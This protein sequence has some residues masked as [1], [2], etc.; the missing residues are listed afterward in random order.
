MGN[1]CYY[2]VL[3]QAC[4]TS[5]MDAYH[6]P[7]EGKFLK[8]LGRVFLTLAMA[9]P[10]LALYFI[11]TLSGLSVA[12]VVFWTAVPVL[13]AMTVIFGLA[14]EAS[15]KC[16]LYTTLRHGYTQMFDYGNEL[17]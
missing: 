9:F 7:T 16:N 17:V 3:V 11:S 5:G 12:M 10:L 1:G 6:M 15:L 2:G 8:T 4:W 14:D 13:L